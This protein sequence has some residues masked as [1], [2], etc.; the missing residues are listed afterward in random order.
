MPKSSDSTTAETVEH[1]H[2]GQV[3]T[4]EAENLPA[5]IEKPKN[6]GGRPKGAK[7]SIGKLS[8]RDRTNI[9]AMK[10]KGVDQRTIARAHGVSEQ[11]ISKFLK[12]QHDILDAVRNVEVYRNT[13]ADMFDAGESMLLKSVVD[14]DAID[15]APLNQRAYAFD[16]VFNARRLESGK[17]TANV[18]THHRFTKGGMSSYKA[19]TEDSSESQ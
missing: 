18:E 4:L 8:N 5:V 7:T 13:R 1:N 14:T 3:A 11:A 2:A 17:S 10:V 12:T 15:K 19:T 6:K 9:V 16:R